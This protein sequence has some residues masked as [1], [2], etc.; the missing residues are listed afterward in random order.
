MC[1]SIGTCCG[2]VCRTTSCCHADIVRQE[3]RL[4]TTNARH[5][6]LE[7]PLECRRAPPAFALLIAVQHVDQGGERDRRENKI[8]PSTQPRPPRAAPHQL[9]ETP[10]DI[11]FGNC[12]SRCRP[13]RRVCGCVQRQRG[14]VD[15]PAAAHRRAAGPVARSW[16]LCGELNP[17]S[18]RIIMALWRGR[19]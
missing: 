4:Q 16:S 7:L 10:C 19:W 1:C 13:N 2:R 15:P 3:A 8:R 12:L 14:R 9:A 6:V 11:A 18:S 5:K 17:F